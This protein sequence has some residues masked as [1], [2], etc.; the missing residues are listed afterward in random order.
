MDPSL[1]IAVDGVLAGA[2]PTC[3][4]MPRFAEPVELEDMAA[5]HARLRERILMWWGACPPCEVYRHANHGPVTVRVG[6]VVRTVDPVAATPP[7]P[8]RGSVSVDT[9][10]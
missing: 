10:S 7:V 9:G 3:P 6:H 4:A 1:A 8:E 5:Y 2:S